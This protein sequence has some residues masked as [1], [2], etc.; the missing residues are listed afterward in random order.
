[1][2]GDAGV[3]ARFGVREL[4]SPFALLVAA[5]I[6]YLVFVYSGVHRYVYQQLA[7]MLTRIIGYQ[8]SGLVVAVYLYGLVVLVFGYAGGVLLSRMVERR[9]AA[10]RAFAW[11]RDAGEKAIAR[12]AAWPIARVAGLGFSVAALGWLVGFGANA[13]QVNILGVASLSDIATRWQQSA[14]LVFVA[15]SQIFF[16]PALIIAARRRWQFAAAAGAFL[17]STVTLG[18]LG[19]R[20]LPAKLVLAAFLAA[21]YRVPRRHL[22]KVVVV[23]LVVF[24]AAFGVVGVM[25]KSG[26]YGPSATAGLGVALL[27]ADS[28]GTMYNLDRIV[29]LTPSTGVYGGRLLRDSALALIPGVKADYANYQLGQYLGGRRYFVVGGKRIDRSVS[30]STSLVGAPYADWGV[31]GVVLQMALLGL[32]FGYL[33]RRSRRALWLVPFLVL[34]ASYVINGVNAGVYNPHAIAITV[35]VIG[36][37]KI[38][39][40]TGDGRPALTP[41]ADGG[42]A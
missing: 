40:L 6:Y 36:V 2:S 12:L 17:A 42:V 5:Y 25:S 9:A 23:A 28:A 29:R 27:W 26:I 34:W 31:L 16:V 13:M 41:G 15:S 3:S 7:G 37:A 1:M 24:L 33:Q 4:L 11:L 30:L 32:L 18:L 19:A 10:P 35:L 22:W 38:D 39:L 20:N 21:V 8:P 14:V